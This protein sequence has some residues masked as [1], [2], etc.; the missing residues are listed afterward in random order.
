LWQIRKPK[1]CLK[2]NFLSLPWKGIGSIE[3]QFLII[4]KKKKPALFFFENSCVGQAK[5]NM[6]VDICQLPSSLQRLL[7]KCMPPSLKQQQ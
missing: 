6:Q 4:Q 3:W 7:L 5:E 1:N 2:S